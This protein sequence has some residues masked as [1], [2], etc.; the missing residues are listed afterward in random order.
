L[1][2]GSAEDHGEGVGWVRNAVSVRVLPVNHI[3]TSS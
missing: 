3:R 2:L 1:R